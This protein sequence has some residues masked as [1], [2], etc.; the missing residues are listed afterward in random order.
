[1]A[2]D[3]DT[4]V[5]EW[6]RRHNVEPLGRSAW[7]IELVNADV[8]D[9]DRDGMDAVLA[10][11][12]SYW[13]LHTPRGCCAATSR[14]C[15]T[16]WSGTASSSS[17]PTGGYGRLPRDEGNDRERRIHL[18]LGFRRGTTRSP[19]GTVANI[20]FRFPDGSRIRDAFVYEWRL[21]TLPEIR[22]I[23]EEAGFRDVTVYWQGTDEKTGEGNG[24]FTPADHGEAGRPAGLPTSPP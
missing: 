16:R 12:F 14:R 22:E 23:L 24:E 1:M 20:H 19:D 11:N 15:A 4:K 18:H 7:R 6:G 2:V 10:M 13:V 5:L 3:I 17:T 21:W 9:V 8:R